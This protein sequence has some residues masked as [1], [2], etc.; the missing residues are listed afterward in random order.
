[1][2]KNKTKTKIQEKIRFYTVIQIV[3]TEHNPMPY[4]TVIC[5]KWS[6]SISVFYAMYH[7][8]KIVFLRQRATIIHPY[9]TGFIY[10]R[11]I[12]R[13]E[14]NNKQKETGKTKRSFITSETTGN[15]A[16]N[17]L[18][19][20]LVVKIYW[21]NNF[22]ED[23]QKNRWEFSFNFKLIHWMFKFSRQFCRTQNQY[24]NLS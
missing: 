12:M 13:L 1:M 22:A 11:K 21:A 24:R 14:S 4:I 6:I 3:I 10:D 20:I 17:L 18:Q 9:Y 16:L 15:I 2:D 5:M 19:R 23:N 8:L 7:S